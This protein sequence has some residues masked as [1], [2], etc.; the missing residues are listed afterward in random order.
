MLTKRPKGK[1]TTIVD[2]VE[3]RL[4]NSSTLYDIII[5]EQ[6]YDDPKSRVHG[7]C[8]VHALYNNN[9][10]VFEI[11]SFDTYKARTSAKKQLK[12]DEHYYKQIYNVNKVYK[13]YV[14]GHK[15]NNIVEIERVKRNE[16]NK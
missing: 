14:T 6:D 11:K 13:F 8:D 10:L 5:K 2:Y 7:E 4:K 1:H 12:K 3:A 9:L 16:Y 15:N